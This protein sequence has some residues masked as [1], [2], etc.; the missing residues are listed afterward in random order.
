[1]NASVP[2]SPADGGLDGA[3]LDESSLYTYFAQRL[4]ERLREVEDGWRQV[5]E[6]A[7]SEEAVK[8]LHRLAHSL[9]G[10]GATFGFLTVTEAARELEKPLKAVVQKAAPH[11]DDSLVEGLLDG[12]RRAARPADGAPPPAPEPRAVFAASE[13]SE[14]SETLES[15]PVEAAAGAEPEQL[16][17][18]LLESDPE[19][20]AQ[21]ARQLGRFGYRVR[22]LAGLSEIEEE[23]ARESPRAILMDLD[24]PAPPDRAQRIASLRHHN[25]AVKV[26]F[27]SSRTDLEARLE[28]VRAGGEAFFIKPVDVGTLIERLDLLTGHGPGEPYRILILDDDPDLANYYAEVLTAAG[29]Q[30]MASGNPLEIMDSIAAFQPDLILLDVYMPSC[31]GSEIAA[32]LRQREGTLSTPVVFLSTE[33]GIEEQLA[34]LSFG[35]DEF[36][37]KPIAPRHLVAAVTARSRHA[38]LLRSL[39]ANDGL[40]GLLNHGTLIQRIES[41]V[42]R[43]GRFGGTLS[44]AMLDVDHFKQINDTYGHA[45]GDRLLR[46]LSLFLKQRLRRSDIIGRYGGDEIAILLPHTDAPTAHQVISGI[47]QSFAQIRHHVGTTTYTATLTGG[48]A[49]YP[50][51]SSPEMLIEAADHALYVAKRAGRGRVEVYSA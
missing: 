15:P 43:A 18:L 4:P 6:T 21:L 31:A 2:G 13:R 36:L 38:R 1:L 32:V 28:A 26:A 16:V 14:R 40:T 24:A 20:S 19:L 9:A 8:T 48:I 49:T 47:C 42:S 12:L 37:T 10:A 5:Q 39:I 41:E 51:L 45:A 30:A 22:Q 29:M 11:P 33:N 35:G 46:S 23:M 34:A 7:W 3:S 27:L 17:V 25:P 50:G 44:C